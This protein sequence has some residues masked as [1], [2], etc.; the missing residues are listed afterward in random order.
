VNSPASNSK[1]QKPAAICLLG[2][3]AIGKTQL[4]LELADKLPVSLINVDSAQIYRGMNIGTGKPDAA[5]LAQYPHQ[6]M[7]IMD[8]SQAYSA[9]DFRDDAIRVMQ[10]AVDAGKT[11]VLVGGT[12]LYFKVLRD[13]LAEMPNA[14]PG[15]R[16]EI[17]ELAANLGWEAVHAE[18]AIVDPES[19]ARIHR[20]DPQ[21]LQRALEVYRL[22]GKS[23]SAHHAA[24]SMKTAADLPCSLH[25]MAIQ[26]ADRAVLHERI[27][28]RFQA[29]LAS[30]LIEEVQELHDRED[31]HIHLN[32][33]KSV[34]YRQIWQYLEGDLDYDGMVER[35]IIA[36]RQLA[37]RQITWLRSWPNLLQLGEP[38]AKSIDNVLKYLESVS[39]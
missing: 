3:T 28:A 32:S 17:E 27:S 13:G 7:D 34:G 20:N 22:T 21:R 16:R 38:P 9:A 31:L 36:T 25:F 23:L 6:L 10:E 19:A 2:P 14:D 26:A 18:L 29:M 11:P 37:K 4:A 8:P 30:G 5:T 1:A 15:I 39:I 24:E 33:I 12:M 35:S